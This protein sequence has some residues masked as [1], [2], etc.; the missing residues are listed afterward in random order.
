MESTVRG[1]I[2]L[3]FRVAKKMET[4]ILR[5]IGTTITIHSFIPS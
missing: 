2:G 5:Y 4:T 1:Y 3:G